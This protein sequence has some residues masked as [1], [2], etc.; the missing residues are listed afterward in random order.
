MSPTTAAAVSIRN[1]GEL[2]ATDP[3]GRRALALDLIEAGLRAV[4]PRRATRAAIERLLARGERLAAPIVIAFGKAARSMA[5]GA[6]DVVDVREG[7]VVGF[8]EDVRPG[9]EPLSVIAS[10]HPVPTERSVAA[11]E[12]VLALAARVGEGDVVLCLVSGGGSAMLEAPAEGVTLEAYAAE[13]K[14]LLAS[15]APIEQINDARRRLSR[16]KGC[17]LLDALAPA[18]VVNVVLSD[19]PGSG[20]EV[21]ASGPTVP[22]RG[23]A[24]EARVVTE[25]AG[26]NLVA[27]GAMLERARAVGLVAADP[28][29]FSRGEAREVGARF[30]EECAARDE[31]VIVWGGETTVELRGD[32]VG[33]RN[34][35]LVL[36][37][38][39]R[40][41]G[42]LIASVGTD[43]IDGASAAAGALLDAEVI[44][45]ARRLR[46][47]PRDFLAR[48]DADTFFE[49]THGRIVTGRTGTNVADVCVYIAERRTRG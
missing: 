28:G 32:G 20:P 31:D 40:F 43:G 9:V 1:R 44:D 6:L 11:G 24:R 5:E 16:I 45:A 4:E 42:G 35:E 27:R 25:I 14:R 46:L 8:D 7:I 10:S 23:D 22:P 17:R 13:T 47:D 21:V 36:G 30:Y 39:G 38:A 29:G 41:A 34:E 2:Q 3:G 15:G 33:G 18:R 26:D 19:V 49:R 37:A 12:A 48:N